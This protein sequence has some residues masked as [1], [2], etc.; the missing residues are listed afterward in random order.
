MN[1][2]LVTGGAGYVGSLLVPA[3][4]KDGYKVKVFDTFWFW[5]SIDSFLCETSLKD[6][7]NLE[8]IKGDIRNSIAVAEAVDGIDYV[9]NLACISNDPSSDLHY[10]FT[11]DVSYNGVI[12]VINH[13]VAANVKHFVHASS[14]SVYGIKEEEKVTE[15][16]IPE[17]LTQYS[18]LKIEI[19][20]YLLYLSKEKNFTT[21]ILRPSTI[22]GYSPRQRLDLTINMFVDQAF[23]NSLI[24]LFGGDQYRPTLH[25]KDMVR[26]YQHIL[27]NPKSFGEIYNCGYENGSVKSFAYLVKKFLPSTD[28]KTIDNPD[29]RSYRT[30]SEKLEQELGFVYKYDSNDAVKEV[31]C[32]FEQGKLP[33][34]KYYKNIEVMKELLKNVN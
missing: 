23:N 13:S 18:K 11:H 8:I 2:V 33:Y 28:I 10:D 22:C 4:L 1:T 24:T 27:A 32:A 29:H 5:E 31:I 19:E 25:I 34:T 30:C 3:L 26:T 20:H 6:N 14:N 7:K 17:P 21:T 15:D 9:I 12:N 16:L